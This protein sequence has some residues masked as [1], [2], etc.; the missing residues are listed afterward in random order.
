M[1]SKKQPK[2][3]RAVH[4]RAFFLA[5]YEPNP[6]DGGHTERTRRPVEPAH[7]GYGVLVVDGFI[8][9]PFMVYEN[10][11]NA[12]ATYSGAKVVRWMDFFAETT[13]SAEFRKRLV[14]LVRP[15]TLPA[16][17][18]RFSPVLWPR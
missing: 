2:R 9:G 7:G 15:L 8:H 16:T 12:G 18:G 4:D 6:Q 14:K 13:A 10:A 1:T 17:Y 5:P 3:V 11:L